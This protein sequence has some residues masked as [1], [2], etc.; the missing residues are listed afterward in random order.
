MDEPH[1]L[2]IGQESG[3]PHREQGGRDRV[4]SPEGV[5]PVVCGDRVSGVYRPLH[6]CW[7]LPGLAEHCRQLQVNPCG[8]LFPFL[9]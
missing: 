4:L 8:I 2:Q 9:S 1:S 6:P 7:G 5:S 3:T